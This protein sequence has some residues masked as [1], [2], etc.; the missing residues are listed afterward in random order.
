M[1]ITSED[2]LMTALRSHF[3]GETQFGPGGHEQTLPSV[4]VLSSPLFQKPLKC[5]VLISTV[6]I[7]WYDR[8]SASTGLYRYPFIHHSTDTGV[9]FRYSI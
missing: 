5:P 9:T 8:H 2:G 6:S 1:R 7:P 3:N 4:P